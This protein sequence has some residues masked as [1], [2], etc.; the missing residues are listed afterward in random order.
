V[1]RC[2]R[3]SKRQRKLER[4]AEVARIREHHCGCLHSD[5]ERKYPFA[6]MAGE[7]QMMGCGH[8]GELHE[9]LAEL[10]REDE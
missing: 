1:S 4:V 6:Q 9:A 2:G 8:N 10:D 7:Y 5:D 3:S